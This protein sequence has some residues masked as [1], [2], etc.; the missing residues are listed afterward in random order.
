MTRLWG[1][2]AALALLAGLAQAQ[3]GPLA[4]ETIT[5]IIATDPGGGYDNY[6][7]LVGRHLATHLGAEVVFQNL[8][9]AGHIIGTNT[10]FASEPDG[11]TIGTFNTGLIYRQLIGDEAIR[12]DLNE[13]SWIGK[14]ASDPRVMVTSVQSG[15]TTIEGLRE[16]GP[17]LFATAGV[18][19]AAYNETRLLERALGLNL[20]PVVGFGAGEGELAMLRGEVVGQI[21]FASSLMPFVEQGNGQ[22]VVWIGGPEQPQ[23]AD[24]T[25]DEVG[26]GIVSLIESTLTLGRLTAAPPGVPEDILAELRR[27]YDAALADPA[28]LAEAEGLGIPIDAASGAEVDRLIEQALNQTPET[29]EIVRSVLLEEVELTEVTAEVLAT[30]NEGREIT[31]MIDGVETVIEPSG[32]RTT[33][34]INGAAGDRAAVTVGMECIFALPEGSVEPVTMDCSG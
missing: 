34:T 13:M 25:V 31:V 24:F 10:L 9:G 26:Q 28:L 23:A 14:A 2:T 1:A 11:L 20:E 3:E 15:I 30:A 6:G 12:F 27:A 21:G 16:G 29:V 5:Y 32:S 22:V 19:S 4:G 17:H 8:P 33:V 7:R 18:G